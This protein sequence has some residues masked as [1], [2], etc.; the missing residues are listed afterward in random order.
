MNCHQTIHATKEKY[1]F[2]TSNIPTYTSLE[3]PDARTHKSSKCID[4]GKK[5]CR[6]SKRCRI[7]N[8]KFYAVTGNRYGVIWPP[9][10]E[11]CE[12]VKSSNYSNVAKSLGVSDNAV[13]KRIKTRASASRLERETNG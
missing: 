4:C 10:D 13:R 3:D 11:L 5:V 9:Y 7:C 8:G 6:Y 12:M 1:Y 2:D